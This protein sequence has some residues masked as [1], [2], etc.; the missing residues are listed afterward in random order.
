M[1]TTGD[2]EHVRDELRCDGCPGL[3][4][5]V[6]PGI[7]VAGDD[8]R[9]ASGGGTLACGDEDEQLHEVVV[10]IAAARLDDEDV[11]VANGL[12]DLDV[13]LSV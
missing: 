1:V 8:G 2:G 11:L 13:D 10:H 9:D 7:G 4:L 6:H 12:G 5:L 3:V